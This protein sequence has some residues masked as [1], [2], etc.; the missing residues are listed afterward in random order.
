MQCLGP[1]YNLLYYI[2]VGR[3]IYNDRQQE[4]ITV[5]RFSG[6]SEAWL[7]SHPSCRGG[8]LFR[9]VFAS[10][11]SFGSILKRINF[12]QNSGFC[13]F[14]IPSRTALVILETNRKSLKLSPFG[15]MKEHVLLI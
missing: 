12:L 8:N 4:L 2:H 9:I 10:L 3:L 7:A 11:V 5:H 6:I 13:P 15:K 1:C 14:R